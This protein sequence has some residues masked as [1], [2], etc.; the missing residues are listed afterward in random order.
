MN[1]LLWLVSL[2]TNG[3]SFET[4]S[5]WTFL[6]MYYPLPVAIR[7]H[8][9]FLFLVWMKLEQ[10]SNFSGRAQYLT[11]VICTISS[12]EMFLLLSFPNKTSQLLIFWLIFCVFL[13]ARLRPR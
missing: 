4:S 10:E 5:N 3:L 7:P 12:I 13:Q 11:P 9:S 8:W 1:I 6:F 2:S